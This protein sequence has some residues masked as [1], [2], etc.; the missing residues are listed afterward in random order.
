MPEVNLTING[1]N[2]IAEQG[3]TVLEAAKENGIFIP[4]L[5][6]DPRLKPYGACRVCLV[7]VEGARGPVPSCATPISEGMVVQTDTVTL[8]EIRKTITELLIANHPMECLTCQSTGNCALQDLAYMFGIEEPRF[9]GEQR[10]YTVEDYNPVIERDHRKCILCGRCVRICDEIMGIRVW[11]FA[12]RGFDAIVTTP[13]ERSLFDTKCVFCGQCVSTCPTGALIEKLSK[14]RGRVWETEQTVTICPY[15]GVGCEI[16]L[17]TKNNE[18]IG[19][20]ADVGLGVNNGNLCVKGRFGFGFINHPDRLQT[21]LV[22]KRGKFV[23][24]TWEEALEVVSKNLAKIKKKYGA[25]AI[26]ALSSAKCTNEENYLM[27]KFMRAVIGTNNID[28]CAR[29]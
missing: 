5:C 20:T 26:A 1:K 19:V 15:C 14:Y 21:P 23:E 7:E 18:V 24:A 6:Y 12:N 3:K 27:Q 4:T 10:K 13:Y 29:L 9:K 17:H 28:H 11:G 22:K 8:Y 25:D 2:I 16:K